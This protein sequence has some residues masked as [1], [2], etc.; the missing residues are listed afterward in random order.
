V[1]YRTGQLRELYGEQ[2]GD[3]ESGLTLVIALGADGPMGPGEAS[4]P[5]GW[6]DAQPV[7]AVP[8]ES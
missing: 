1:R 5:D 4:C 2:L 7:A 6:A 3:P 8:G